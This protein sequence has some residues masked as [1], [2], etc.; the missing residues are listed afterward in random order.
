MVGSWLSFNAPL[1]VKLVR[2]ASLLCMIVFGLFAVTALPSCVQLSP[3]G[4]HVDSERLRIHVETL[5]KKF[6]PRDYRNLRNLNLCA[7][8]IAGEFR[9]AGAEV[10][11]QTYEVKGKTYRNIIGEFGPA[12]ASRIVIGAHYD[13]CGDTPGADDNASGTAGLIELAHLLGQE[14]WGKRIELVAYTLEEPPFFRTGNMG[15]ARH[16]QRHRGNG[17]EIDG[18]ISLEMIGYFSDEKGS[19]KFPSL[20]LK[21]FYPDTGNFIAVIGS[22]GDRRLVKQLKD[23]MRGATDLPVHAMCAPKSFPGLDFSDHLNYWNNDYSAAMI[24]DT[25]FMRNGRYHSA[26]DTSE[27]LDYERMSKVVL[28]VYEAVRQMGTDNG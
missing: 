28:G 16:A 3:S 11:E 22:Y 26:H 4:A 12:S 18:M 1:S 15:S 5:S 6:I 2:F 27:T 23:S 14:T 13:A 24:T 7:D 21:M 17:V 9:K 10:S 20:L 25:A 19:Q 8:Y